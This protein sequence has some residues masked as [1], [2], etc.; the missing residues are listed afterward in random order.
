MSELPKVAGV[1]EL[2]RVLLSG[3]KRPLKS[4]RNKH[5]PPIGA[6]AGQEHWK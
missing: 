5:V 6:V 1:E 4:K 2:G 3:R